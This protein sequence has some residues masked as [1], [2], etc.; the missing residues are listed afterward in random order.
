MYID[1]QIIC[2]WTECHIMLDKTD[3]FKLTDGYKGKALTNCNSICLLSWKKT[4][5]WYKIKLP[6][7]TKSF[8]IKCKYSAI[9]IL[10]I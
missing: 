1:P 7:K 8:W 5:L 3:L 6:E 2:N 4:L 9:L 10:L